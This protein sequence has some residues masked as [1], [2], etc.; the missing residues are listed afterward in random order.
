MADRSVIEIKYG[1]DHYVACGIDKIHMRVYEI[2]D[3]YR[4]RTRMWFP[5]CT[6]F[7]Y[8]VWTSEWKEM[9]EEAIEKKYGPVVGIRDP[10]PIE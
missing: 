8:E 6:K 4:K 1:D 2:L 7:M 5:S 10:A 3:G 9:S